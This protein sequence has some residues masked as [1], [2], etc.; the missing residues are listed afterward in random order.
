[1]AKAMEL[2]TV[3]VAH[4]KEKE[5]DEVNKIVWYLIHL[6]YKRKKIVL[7]AVENGT[8]DAH[9]VQHVERR[10]LNATIKTIF[11]DIIKM[12]NGETCRI[13]YK[14]HTTY[15]YCLPDTVT[16]NHILVNLN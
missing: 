5:T 4:I 14:R 9:S 8:R 11:S 2:A 10:A 15:S 7:D 16:I 12:N 13:T 3:N 6:N 1:M